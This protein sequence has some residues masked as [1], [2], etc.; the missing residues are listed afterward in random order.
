MTF[1]YEDQLQYAKIALAL[2]ESE[3][4]NPKSLE[5]ILDFG[6]LVN[7]YSGEN[8]A[9][10]YD[11]IEYIYEQ[12]RLLKNEDGAYDDVELRRELEEKIGTM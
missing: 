6:E 10:V 4:V 12:L 1:T 9:L 7:K 5:V 2:F 3:K 8:N 11:A